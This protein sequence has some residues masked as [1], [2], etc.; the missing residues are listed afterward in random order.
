MGDKSG[1]GGF[2]FQAVK[3][4]KINLRARL[5]QAG[6]G[7]V[8]AWIMGLRERII[9]HPGIMPAIVLSDP[10]LTVSLPPHLTAAT[11]MDALAHSLEAY[12]APGFHH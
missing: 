10:A 1:V 2:A 3:R 6:F 7:G 11:G 5:E 12:C 9:F 8:F 4:G